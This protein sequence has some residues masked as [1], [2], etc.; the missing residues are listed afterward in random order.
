[1]SRRSIKRAL[2]KEFRDK[3]GVPIGAHND[4]ID[5][6]VSMACEDVLGI[7]KFSKA[8]RAKSIARCPRCYRVSPGFYYTTRCDGVTCVPGISTNYKVQEFIE[9]GIKHNIN[10]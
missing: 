5:Y 7:S 3:C 2:Q 9:R 1:M 10:I 4:L 8:R 6:I